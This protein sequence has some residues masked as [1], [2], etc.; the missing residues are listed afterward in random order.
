MYLELLGNPRHS[1]RLLLACVTRYSVSTDD[2]KTN[3]ETS[4][5][6]NFTSLERESVFAEC[7]CELPFLQTVDDPSTR[8][9]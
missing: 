6:L 2:P 3:A 1:I 4:L 9:V 8:L 7:W 5:A